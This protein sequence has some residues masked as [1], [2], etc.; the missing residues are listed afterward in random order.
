VPASRRGFTLIELLVVIAIIAILA[1]I[2]FPV[3]SRARAKARQASCLSNER[4]IGLAMQM[5]CSDW[6]GFMPSLS[7]QKTV[8]PLNLPVLPEALQPYSRNMQVFQC[9]SDSG[10]YYLSELT[11]Y[12]WFD[13]FNGTSL[14][15]P[16][17]MGYSLRDVPY[18]ADA[19]N[20][21]HGG[22]DP[23]GSGTSSV[24]ARNCLFVDGHAKFLNRPPTSVGP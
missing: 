5:Y 2:L 11:S 9:P 15:D 10:Q 18:L 21:W 14:D 19:K 3:F 6:D 1:A 7:S 16:Q 13:L 8:N 17:W 20:A 23:T 22:T 4:Q 12:S 24:F